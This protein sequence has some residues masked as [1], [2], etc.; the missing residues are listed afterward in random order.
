MKIFCQCSGKKTISRNRGDYI[1]E[2]QLMKGLSN[3]AEVYYSGKRFDPNI[4]N[5]GMKD[6]EGTILDMARR[7]K[8]D[9]YYVRNNPKLFTKLKGKKI[10]F[11]SPY[12]RRSFEG[13]DAIASLTGSLTERLK[14]GIDTHGYPKNYK[15]DKVYT[16][17][18]IVDPMFKPLQNH[19]KTKKIRESIGG[20]FIMGHFGSLRKSCFPY[21]FSKILPNIKKEHP[22]VNV[23]FS[24]KKS[25][26]CHDLLNRHIKERSFAYA[27]MPYAISAC[28]LILYNFRGTDGHF[29]GSMK[30]LE[31]MSCGVPV[32]A[33][34]F[35][36]RVEELGEDYEMF[37][38]F[39]ANGG[40]FSAKIE[41]EM[42]QKLISF[43]E[44]VSLRKKLR[45]KVLGRSKFYQMM[46]S[47]KRLKRTME[48][49]LSRKS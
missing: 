1:T 31:A 44:D 49:I 2:I 17:H 42:K 21:S 32:F 45:E 5:F 48:E 7:Q 29:V 18:Q 35:D 30:I 41:K 34:R 9:A 20:G 4:G 8:Y 37:H 28:D 27:D 47:K 36:A 10:Y 33:P 12:D 22:E 16:F 39:S 40:R 23:V 3:F 14:N 38:S 46:Q 11:F 13:A 43:I 24:T 6:Y 19:P 25:Q 15:C 26:N